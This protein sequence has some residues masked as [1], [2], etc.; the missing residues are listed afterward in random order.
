MG[1]FIF[2]SLGLLVVA[3]S[4][5]GIGADHHCPFDWF[6]HNVSCYKLFK[7]WMTWD[8]AQRYCTEQQENSHLASIKDVGESVKLSN[9]ISQGWRIFDVWVGLRL[10]KR[11]NMWEWSDGS[12]ITYTSWKQGEPNNFLNKESCAALTVGSRFLQWNDKD[13]GHRHPFVCKF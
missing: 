8:E 12:N 4:L 13:C 3:F 2:A 11:K 10:S 6:S 7:S 5:S 1:R 9:H